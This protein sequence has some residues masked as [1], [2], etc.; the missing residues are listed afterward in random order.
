LLNPSRRPRSHQAR[1][2]L[3]PIRRRHQAL[4]HPPQ[5]NTSQRRRL[6]LASSHARIK[7]EPPRAS[8]FQ[9]GPPPML[10]SRRRTSPSTQLTQVLPISSA[11]SHL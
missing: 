10:A 11:P 4:P 9:L 8:P 1:P 7:L 2:P 3:R 6:F 5:H